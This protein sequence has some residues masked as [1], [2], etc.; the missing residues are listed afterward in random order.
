MFIA[1]LACGL[2]TGCQ[3]DVDPKVP[4][5]I[6]SF[7]EP[8][9][10]T[11]YLLYCPSSYNRELLWPLVVVCHTSFPDSPNQQIRHWTEQAEAKG[12]I[13]VAPKLKGIMRALPPKA[14]KQ[15]ELQREDERRILAAVRH[16]RAG[17]SISGDRI[18]IYGWSG[19]C[20]AALYTG[21]KNPDVF[22]AISLLQPKFQSGFMT[23]VQGSI[24]PFQ[25]IYVN[26][27]STDAIIGHYAR[28]CVEWLR[29]KGT[30]VKDDGIG[31]A[32]AD[33]THRAVEFFESVI[34]RDP[35]VRVYAYPAGDGNP[36]KVHFKVRSSYEP[37]AYRW[38][39]GDGSESP[40]AE[41]EYVF[42]A[43]GTYR[44][45]VII[46]SKGGHQDRRSVDVD[47]PHLRVKG[48][49]RPME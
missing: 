15:I 11:E 12:F 31:P 35:M 33:Q 45:T 42:P 2:A 34:R 32:R 29:S 13:V 41:P 23:D 21:L 8:E 24:D 3:K 25:P 40:V 6:Q 49:A 14:A 36:L 10:D 17:Y 47:V 9:G 4:E 1:A 20:H 43:P 28:D 22:R 7:H 48:P 18:F 46:E 37:T 38:V 30:T 27:S 5:P 26:Y 44:V 16:V 39:F 19:G